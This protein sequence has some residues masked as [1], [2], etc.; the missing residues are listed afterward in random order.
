M[1]PGAPV[2]PAVVV[3]T[4][5]QMHHEQNGGDDDCELEHGF[6]LSVPG[7]STRG[8]GPGQDRSRTA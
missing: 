8:C 2:V 4:A 5:G 7:L 6:L 1:K 3:G